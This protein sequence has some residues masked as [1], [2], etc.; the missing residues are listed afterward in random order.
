MWFI[1]IYIYMMECP[2]PCKSLSCP[3]QVLDGL[4]DLTYLEF[5]AGEGEVFRCIRGDHHPSCAVDLEY[6]EGRGHAM[7]VNS[8]SG[9]AFLSLHKGSDWM[10]FSTIYIYN[11]CIS[12][13]I[14]I[15][16][17]S[18][19]IQRNGFESKQ[20]NTGYFF[21]RMQ[22]HDMWSPS[23]MFKCWSIQG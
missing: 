10:A 14:Y 9:L 12:M 16:V 13:Y 5:F 21:F 15:H 18:M 8:P 17:M 3:T 6:M 1:N 7:D 20:S 2:C 4:Q 19:Y 11:T 23:T 22:K